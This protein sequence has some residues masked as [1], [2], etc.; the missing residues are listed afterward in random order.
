MLC[1]ELKIKGQLAKEASILLST[2]STETKNQALAAMAEALERHEEEILAANQKDIERAKEKGMGN[3]MLDR[4][5]LTPSRIKEMAHG[6]RA[7][8]A[9]PDPVGE[10]EAVWKG[11]QA[12]E[13]GRMR[14]PLGVIGII[15]EAR[16]NVT[17][18]AAGLCLKTGNAVILRGGSEALHSNITITRVISQA[19]ESAGIPRGSIQLI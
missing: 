6:L 3:A 16:P 13:I 2:L 15:Y 19:A 4:L 9:L 11:A 5:L 10:I 14:V 7:L 12:I 1:E 8:I 17:V 18:D